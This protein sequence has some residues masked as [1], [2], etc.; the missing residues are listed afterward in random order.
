MVS[1]R[2]TCSTPKQCRIDDTKSTPDGPCTDAARRAG[3]RKTET[4]GLE[5]KE[6]RNLLHVDAGRSG[7]Q[8]WSGERAKWGARLG[9]RAERLPGD[10][11]PSAITDRYQ[12]ARIT[13]LSLQAGVLRMCEA[14]QRRSSH[15]HRRGR[16][17]NRLP[18]PQLRLKPPRICRT[19]SKKV[20][21]VQTWPKSRKFD[22]HR[23]KTGRNRGLAKE[24]IKVAKTGRLR[25]RLVEFALKSAKNRATSCRNC[26]NRSCWGQFR[27]MN[28]EIRSTTVNFVSKSVGEP[29]SN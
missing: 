12:A 21:V 18:L 11:F 2:E 4:P 24:L 10:S 29:M 3:K 15:E 1:Q 19:R 28:T 17:R 26:K 25:R 27:P 22:Q 13:T 23:S 20:E 7:G 9:E 16:P 5:R 8:D 14:R 6:K